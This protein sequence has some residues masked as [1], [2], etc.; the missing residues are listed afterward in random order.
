MSKQQIINFLTYL[1]KTDKRSE[2]LYQMFSRLP[3]DELKDYQLKAIEF[4]KK[5]PHC[6][7]WCE[8]G[9]GK[10]VSTLTALADFITPE[11][12]VLIV[13]T[14]QICETVWRQ[15]VEKWE[16]LQ[17]L[18]K[19]FY[20]VGTPKKRIAL[21]KQNN[22]IELISRDLIA[23]LV[24]YYKSKWPY[25]IVVIDEA[26]SFK[27]PSSSR[28]KKL[29]KVIKKSTRVIELTGT[30][31]TA[32]YL[33]IWSQIYLLDGGERLE[34]TFTAYK[35]L[36]FNSDYMGYNWTLKP[37]AKE[38]IDAKIKDIC[39]TLMAEDYLKMPERIDNFIELELPSGVRKKYKELKKNL[40]L[41]LQNGD[42]IIANNAAGLINKLRQICNGAL[43]IEESL[44]SADKK[45]EVLHD[46]KLQ[47]LEQIIEESGG[48]PVLIGYNFKFDKEMIKARFGDLVHDIKDEGVIERW[49]AGKV[50]ILI[51][52]P[53][54]AGHGINLQHGGNIMVWYGLTWSL[55]LY[56]QFNARLRR[57]GQTRPVICHHILIKDS[58]E[59][60][61]LRALQNNHLT[62][63]S[64][65]NAMKR[66][67]D[68]W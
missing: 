44:G 55:E 31:A 10:T 46:E 66:D 5:T 54:S 68:S 14:K 32:G 43:Y 29:R 62:Q 64:L 17:E 57:L 40:L 58:V 28:F 9:L 34:K 59:Q 4:I 52:H 41:E 36:Y 26:R 30:P 22:Q 53:A 38:K 19:P 42:N 61:V 48:A 1:G 56:L 24:E 16:H 51:A 20:I 35:E 21:L 39:M 63:S 23:W 15:E 11:D 27:S 12:K 33:D 45:S 18:S 2:E 3:K 47:R 6:A 37:S 13:A 8:M 7:L 49:D 65:L 25:T 67:I 50:P 60:L